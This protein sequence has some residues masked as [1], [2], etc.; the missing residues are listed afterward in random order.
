MYIADV[1]RLLVIASNAG[2]PGHPA[3][4]HNLVAQ[5]EVRVEVGS[6]TYRA[7]AHVLDGA[8]RQELWG[9]IVEAHHFFG[10]HQAKISRQIPVIA[11]DRQLD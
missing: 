9:K 4:Y 1:E 11:L 6:E 10:E 3:W 7:K 2:A 5:P 8:A